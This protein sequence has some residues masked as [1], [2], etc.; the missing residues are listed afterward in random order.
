MEELDHDDEPQSIAHQFL[1]CANE[2]EMTKSG[3][4]LMRMKEAK[5]TCRDALFVG[6]SLPSIER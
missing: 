5:Y 2:M 3:A 4:Y 1:A 6:H